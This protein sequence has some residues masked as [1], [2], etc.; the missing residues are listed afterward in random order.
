MKFLVYRWLRPPRILFIVGGLAL[1]GTGF[2][3]GALKAEEQ[4]GFCIA[5]HTAPEQTY[6]DRS[7]LALAQQQP[8]L[9]L[10]SAHYGLTNLKGNGFRCIDCHRGD[11]S[12]P[13]RATTLALGARDALIFI[14]GQADETIE[15]NK[16]EVPLL[17]NAS[18]IQCHTD[19]LLV[20]GFENHFHNKLPA[21]YAAWQAGGKLTA[22]AN[23]P[24][25]NISELKQYDTTVLCT[26]CH[27]AH[28]HIE[29]AELQQYLDVENTVFPACVVCHREVEH[30]PLQLAP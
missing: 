7:R 16:S 9:D 2:L 5:C 6:Y 21:A 28:V 25:T 26:D 17:H 12:L 10:T 19:T 8:Y 27:R 13:R 20:A 30:G 24:D 1:L 22:P 18:C 29:G 3:C 4:D 23:I 11:S 14:T 15:K